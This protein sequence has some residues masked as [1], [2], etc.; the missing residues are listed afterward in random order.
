M[1]LEALRIKPTGC[2]P[3]APR[4]PPERK[5]GLEAPVTR[6]R[7]KL[8]DDATQVLDCWDQFAARDQ[9]TIENR[10]DCAP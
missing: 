10:L 9:A 1:F 8:R 5:A 4:T 6:A 3:G 2:N 7:M